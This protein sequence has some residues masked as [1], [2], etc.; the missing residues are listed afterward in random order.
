[1]QLKLTGVAGVLAVVLG[2]TTGAAQPAG[3][4]EWR[5]AHEAA[6]VEELRGLVSLPNVAGND[7]DMQQNAAH[8]QRLF[9]ARQFKVETVGGPGSPMVFASLDVANAAGTL[10]FYIHYDGQPV[11]ASEWT[12]C[13]PFT[14]CLWGANGPVADDPARTSFDPEWRMYGR[15]TSDDKGP[16]VALL[17]AVDALRATASGPRWNVRVVLDGEEEA[18]SANFHRFA[19]ARAGALKTD[20]AITLDG[21]RHPSGRPTVYFGV[22]GGAG[23][24]VTVYGARGDLHSGNYGNWA[25]DP[26]MRLAK[27]LATMKDD[28]G[29]V[30]I[31]DFY[32]DVRPLTAT[33]K[34]AL[35]AA[36]DVEAVLAR[37]FAVAT[38]ERP[39]ERLEAK[40]NQ[41]TLSIL[42]MSTSGI[43]GRSAIPGSATARIEVRMVKDLVPDTQN[44]LITEHIRQQGYVIVSGRDPTDEERRTH[45]LIARVDAR[46]GSTAS[47]VSMDDPKAQAVVTALTLRGVPPVQLPTLG[48]G[49]PF[50]T[51][52]DQYQMPT[53]GV[54]I[55]NFDNNQHGPD[56]NLRLQNLW[57]GIEMLA[58][59]M[60]MPR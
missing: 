13:Q 29:H 44:A 26:S 32:R 6:I 28:A 11:D 48:G 15:S 24:T 20:L 19:T 9:T 58:A 10:T 56:E 39:D 49:L 43:S 1:M 30:L 59:L 41:P 46:R 53:V 16:I 60:S 5:S 4:A 25:P 34:A 14:P 3:I 36:P 37:D 42:E 55:V 45:R 2:A 54:S 47:R 18:G 8:L 31:K 27:L 50:G 51:F 38:P 22:R 12:R 57:E 35:A 23:V 21:P 17:N 33:E 40:L 7:A 52:S